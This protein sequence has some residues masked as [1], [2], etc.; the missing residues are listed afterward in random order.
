MLQ[1][2]SAG[3]FSAR[4]SIAIVLRL[5]PCFVLTDLAFKGDALQYCLDVGF[6]G[7]GYA[8]ILLF[9]IVCYCPVPR[10]H[11]GINFGWIHLSCIA[12]LFFL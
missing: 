3:P 4:S 6:Y 9:T 12:T 8:D 11:Y 10:H 5:A 7:F 1:Y 2:L